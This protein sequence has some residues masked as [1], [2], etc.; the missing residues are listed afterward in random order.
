MNNNTVSD[1]SATGFK[2]LTEEQW[3][4]MSDAG[5]GEARAL[6][7]FDVTKSFVYD[8]EY[9]IFPVNGGYHQ[10]AMAQ[11]CAFHHG[12]EDAGKMID[13]LKKQTSK[14]WET[15]HLADMFLEKIPGT[16]FRSSVGK[17]VTAGTRHSLT[18]IEKRIFGELK[19]AFED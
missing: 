10:Q 17:S 11:L 9:G 12:F 4:R 2:P 15:S 6:P 3:Y 7:G 13:H 16:A 19:Y 14:R 8:R 5:A 18:P 1:V